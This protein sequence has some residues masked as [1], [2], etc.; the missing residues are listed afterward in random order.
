MSKLT[1]TTRMILMSTYVIAAVAL[2]VGLFFCEDKFTFFLGIALGTG[3]STLKMIMMERS[4]KKSL[5]M[6]SVSAGNYIRL[7]FTIRYFLTGVVLALAALVPTIDLWGAV[8][9]VFASQVSVHFVNV[10]LRKKMK[11]L[12]TTESL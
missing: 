4:V 10:L 9:G 3:F 8:I 5:D 1:D 6:N 11:T 7:N 2:V 12:E